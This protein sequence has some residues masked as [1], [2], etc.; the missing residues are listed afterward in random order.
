MTIIRKS[1]FEA[2]GGFKPNNYTGDF[3]AWHDL[4]YHSGVLLMPSLAWVRIHAQQQSEANRTDP[5]VYFSASLLSYQKLQ[6][7]ERDSTEFASMRL[8]KLKSRNIARSIVYE[9]KRNGIRS[10][11]KLKRLSGWT[12]IE[13][14]KAI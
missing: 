5:T 2:I 8:S 12:W 1:H 9:A 11:L 6:S 7:F 4:A 3:E 14:L 10:M 13:V